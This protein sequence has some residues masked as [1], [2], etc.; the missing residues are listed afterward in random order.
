MSVIWYVL[1]EEYKRLK[2][3]KKIYSDRIK[4]E[5]D[6]AKLKKYKKCLKE[7]L[8]NYNDILQ[9]YA[10]KYRYKRG[11]CPKCDNTGYAQWCDYL[12][13]Q[14]Y[15]CDCMYGKALAVNQNKDIIVEWYRSWRTV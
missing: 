5:T 3:A 1:K 15:T 14:A 9:I 2:Q 6:P 8:K 12:G 10:I 4:T 11:D 7:V 13:W